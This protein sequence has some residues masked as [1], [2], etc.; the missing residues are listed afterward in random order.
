MEFVTEHWNNF[1]QWLY[2]LWNTQILP[3]WFMYVV[4]LILAI[5]LVVTLI[6][7][8][9]NGKEKQGIRRLSR[10]SPPKPRY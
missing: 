10:K 8:A 1:L 4:I 6:V 7:S 5:L 3:Y 9:K 2:D